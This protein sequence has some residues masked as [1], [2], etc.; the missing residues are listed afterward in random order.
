VSSRKAQVERSAGGV[1]LR[2]IDVEPSVLLIRD[3]YR[4]WGLPNGHLEE[5]EDAKQAAIRE[6]SEETGLQLLEVGPEVATINW[7]FRRR[8]TLVQKF[9]TFF[10]MRSTEGNAIPEVDEGITEC[11]WLPFGEA[12]ERL[13][14]ENAR[15][16]LRI[17]QQM[18]ERAD[19]PFGDD[20]EVQS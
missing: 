1:V 15:E 4:N 6:V 9:C 18:L 11:V 17:V 3:P 2:W 8:G 13:T 20:K 10:L 12:M 5:G 16:T 14:Y 19:A 7:Y